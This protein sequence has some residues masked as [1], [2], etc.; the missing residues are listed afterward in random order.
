[1]GWKSVSLGARASFPRHFGSARPSTEVGRSSRCTSS[2]LKIITL[3]RADTPTHWP[4]GELNRAGTRARVEGSIGARRD[5]SARNSSGGE[6]S[7][8]STSAG[9]CEPSATS[10]LA[11][12]SSSSLRTATEIPV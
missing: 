7:V 6:F 10:W 12:T 1:M 9:E 8:N 3:T 2:V 11:K 5:L 4:S